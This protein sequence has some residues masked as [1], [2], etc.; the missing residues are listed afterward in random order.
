MLTK[1]KNCKN[2]FVYKHSHR[3]KALM[4][5]NMGSVSSLGTKNNIFL[6]GA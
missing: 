4:H 5:K 6:F 2:T 3:E 1:I